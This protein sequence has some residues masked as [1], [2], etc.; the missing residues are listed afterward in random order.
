MPP[1]V[2]M[3]YNFESGAMREQLGR[4]RNGGDYWLSFVG[5][6]EPFRHVAASA[7]PFL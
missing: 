5:P 2:T 4:Y 3:L 1:G 7:I 6:A